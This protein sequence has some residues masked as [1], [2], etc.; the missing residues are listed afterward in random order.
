MKIKI[1]FLPPAKF[2]STIL[3]IEWWRNR[4]SILGLTIFS[5]AANH[6]RQDQQPLPN[7]IANNN[8]D[9]KE[10]REGEREF[11]YRIEMTVV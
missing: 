7:S 9:R 3:N 6:V 11:I 1:I 5:N 10:E 4:T 8:R 2:L